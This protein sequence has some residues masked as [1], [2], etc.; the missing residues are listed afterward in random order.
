MRLAMPKVEV[1]LE[2]R[3]LGRQASCCDVIT[4]ICQGKNGNQCDWMMEKE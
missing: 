4:L 1:L 2:R 3:V